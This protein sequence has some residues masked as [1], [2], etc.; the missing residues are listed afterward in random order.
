MLRDNLP[1]L[2]KKTANTTRVTKLIIL[3][4]FKFFLKNSEWIS[5]NWIDDKSYNTN[6]SGK[7]DRIQSWI[8]MD[9]TRKL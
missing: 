1:R 5:I 9:I 6:L 8:Y 7:L 3:G 2:K 4:R